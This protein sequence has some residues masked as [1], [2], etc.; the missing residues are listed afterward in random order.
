MVTQWLRSPPLVEGIARPAGCTCCSDIRIFEVEGGMAMAGRRE[1]QSGDSKLIVRL[2]DL[3]ID[4][5][6][7]HRY[8]ALLAEEIKASVKMEQGV[9]MLHAVSV[10]GSPAQIR[11]FEVYADQEAYEAHL[12]SPHFLKYKTSTSNMVRSLRLLETD[13]IMLCAKDG[14]SE[15]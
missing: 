14:L 8:K 1:R 5:A 10:K 2:A 9:L 13:P 6:Q 7:L 11:I 12:A 15:I 4:P 3:E